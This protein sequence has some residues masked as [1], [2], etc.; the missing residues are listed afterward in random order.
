[1]GDNRLGGVMVMISAGAGALDYFPCCYGQSRSVFRGP[2][3][4]LSGAYVAVLGGSATFGKYVAVPYPDLVEQVTGCPVVNL[5]AL[6]GGP[7]VFLSDPAVLKVASQAQVAVVQITGAEGLSNPLYTV[8]GRRNDRFLGAS[9]ALT[10]LFPEVDFTD[11]HFVRHLLIVLAGTDPERFAVVVRAL[12]ANWVARMRQLLA[13]LPPR[14]ILL[15]LAECAPPVRAGGVDLGAGPLF[16]DA[17]MLDALCPFA[18]VLVDI[19][20]SANARAEG[21]AAMQVPAAERA[22]ASCLPGIGVHREIAEVLA[23]T[24]ARL[25]HNGALTPLVLRQALAHA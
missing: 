7:D 22:L 19:T 2:M 4:D 14:R 20:P 11:I 10:A 5:G 12:K 1:M 16:V 13:H 21:L 6:H 25:L 9:P 15:L 3:R 23:P 8:H 17:G 24:V 18:E